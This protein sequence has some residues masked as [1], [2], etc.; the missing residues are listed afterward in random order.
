MR[1]CKSLLQKSSLELNI[2][3]FEVL[4]RLEKILPKFQLQGSNFVWPMKNERDV[5]YGIILTCV[6]LCGKVFSCFSDSPLSTKTRQADPKK[7]NGNHGLYGN[8]TLKTA[9][10][11]NLHDWQRLMVWEYQRQSQCNKERPPT[12]IHP[13]V[14][15]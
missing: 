12:H 4:C 15:I 9:K 7:S 1:F 6:F 5:T 13:K 14:N 2:K 11:W 10:N 8:D 3:E